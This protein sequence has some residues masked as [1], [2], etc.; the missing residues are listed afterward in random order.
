MESVQWVLVE[1]HSPQQQT[2]E[3]ARPAASAPDKRSS[4]E[5]TPSDRQA[6]TADAIYAAFVWLFGSGCY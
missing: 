5:N 2:T 4:G 1:S 3:A 6:A